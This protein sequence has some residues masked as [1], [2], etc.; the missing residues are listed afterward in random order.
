MFINLQ[1]ATADLFSKYKM[2]E[3]HLISNRKTTLIKFN[4]K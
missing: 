3:H 4:V 2:Y 1:K